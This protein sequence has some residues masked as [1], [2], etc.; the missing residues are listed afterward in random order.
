M[1]LSMFARS[2]VL[3]LTFVAGTAFVL[4]PA[5]AIAADD[6]KKSDSKVL[7]IGDVAPAIKVEKYLKGDPISEFKKG[8]VY[9]V[10]FWATWCGPCIRAFPHVSE[11]QEKYKDQVTVVGVNIWERQYNEELNTKISDFMKKHGD[12]MRYTV[13]FDGGA[14]YMSDKYM[15]A[16]GIDS[17]PHAF[18]VNQ[19]GKIAWIGHPASMDDALSQVVSKKWDMKKAKDARQKEVDAEAAAQKEYAK[20][21]PD[22]KKAGELWQSGK[23]DEAALLMFQVAEKAPNAGFNTGMTGFKYML[24]EG[25]DTKKAYEFADKMITSGHADNAQALNAIAWTI[26][27]P[28]L[29]ISDRNADIALKAAKRASELTGDKDPMILDTLAHAYFLKGDKAKAVE[30]E[31]KAVSLTSDADLKGDLQKALE[32]FKK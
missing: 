28:D 19:D 30:I 17:I 32:K 10:E 8:H 11:L 2:L 4:A 9:V 24:T 5:T 22:M 20:V 31:E 12:N 27:D 3:G 13:A 18:I 7:T 29:T 23:K 16:A 14:K 15:A 6:D 21:A 26:V 1:K 25:K